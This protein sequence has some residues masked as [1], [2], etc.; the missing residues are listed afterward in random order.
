MENQIK[1]DALF[2]EE[3]IND[4]FKEEESFISNE[5]AKPKGAN[6]NKSEEETNETISCIPS[7][8]FGID[9]N[10]SPIKK[11]NK[12]KNKN[13]ANLTDLSKSESDENKKSSFKQKILQQFSN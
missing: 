7:E 4:K 5:N 11:T 10:I 1:K 3:E 12:E 9:L 2:E 6:E 13:L 8:Q